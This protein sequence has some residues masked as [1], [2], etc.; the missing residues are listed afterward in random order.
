[1]KETR[2]MKPTLKDVA[3]ES[4]VSL[5]TASLV[6][7]NKSGVSEDTRSIVLAAAKKLSYVTRRVA[8]APNT[9]RPICFMKISKHGLIV[10]QE[11]KGFIADYIDG[12]EKEAY[13]AGYSLE[14]R[15]YKKFEINSLLGDIRKQAYSGV[16]IL[17]TELA[18]KDILEFRE[19][20]IPKIFIDSSYPFH[21]LDFVNMDNQ[22]AIYTV[23]KTCVDRGMRKI[24]LLKSKIET[25]NFELRTE[26]F[27][28]AL[29]YFGL[30]AKEEWEFAIT[31]S[32]DDA[33]R[34]M[35]NI[36]DDDHELPEVF[37]CVT[38]I[39][40]IGVMRALKEREI[41]VPD[42]ISLIGFDDLP[43]C[44]MVDPSLSSVKVPKKLMGK[45]A[46]Q[47]LEK[48]INYEKRVASEKTYIGCQLVL[49]GS[50]K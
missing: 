29:K 9:T 47:Y 15:S 25:R 41:Q 37:F 27:Y 33:Y 20:E 36:V 11:H 43:L 38:D 10:D 50:I 4:G 3:R 40:G 24:G 34:D 49:R 14:V 2:N 30:E 12:I 5:A 7:N 44:Q 19:L 21:S 6:L 48:M 8:T 35:L 42:D 1:M 28:E 46:F 13:E 17:A 45:R 39:I 22:S 23:I 18:E 31:P 32:Y 16:I 26:Y